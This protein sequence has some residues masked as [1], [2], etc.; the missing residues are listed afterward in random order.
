MNLT[1]KSIER[2]QANND[3]PSFRDDEFTG[4]G[5][6][7]E[8]KSSGGRKSFS[9]LFWNAKVAGQVVFKSLGEWPTTSVRDAREKAKQWAG[10]ASKWKEAG[11]PEVAE[12]V[13]EFLFAANFH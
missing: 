10:K 7:I 1:E 9:G 11:C 12:K 13:I 3:R 2:L 4:L 8:P 6:R 5:I